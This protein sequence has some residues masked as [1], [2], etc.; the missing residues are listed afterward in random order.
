MVEIYNVFSGEGILAGNFWLHV[1][2]KDA[3]IYPKGKKKDME[4]IANS[5]IFMKW[6]FM[7]FC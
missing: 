4:K 3:K 5:G 2:Q 1:Y 7:N 6:N